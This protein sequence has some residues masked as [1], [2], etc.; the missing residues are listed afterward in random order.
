MLALS[1]GAALALL[2]HS[3][4]RGTLLTA[5]LL[6]LLLLLPTL[7]PSPS[8]RSLGPSRSCRDGRGGEA[9]EPRADPRV[10]GPLESLSRSPHGTRDEGLSSIEH[11]APRTLDLSPPC[12]RVLRAMTERLHSLEHMLRD[13]IELLPSS[14]G[15]PGVL[16]VIAELIDQLCREHACVL[17]RIPE[18]GDH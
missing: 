16:V 12:L 3:L 10:E 11:T 2:T 14:E 4:L 6:L 8:G 5:L 1:L 15:V 17:S 7:L 9:C 13:R 18:I